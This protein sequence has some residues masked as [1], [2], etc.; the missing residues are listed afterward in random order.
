MFGYVRPYVPELKVKENELYNAVYC[1]LCR[2]M[3]KTTG[4]VSRLSLSYDMVFLAL[5]RSAYS[6]NS[7]EIE[8]KRCF[9]HPL[10]KKNTAKDCE[11]LRYC[12]A[13]S[14]ELSYRDMLDKINDSHG[15]RKLFCRASLPAM[16][17]AKKKA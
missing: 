3:G 10:K 6:G 17:R 4:T 8:R 12:A 11:I 7:F 1:G 2:S 16:K 13:V 5:V 15:C 14:A 9:V